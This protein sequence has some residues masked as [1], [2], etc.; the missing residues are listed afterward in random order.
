M[1][2]QIRLLEEALGARLFE[3]D[4]RACLTDAGQRLLPFIG[5]AFDTIERASAKSS[6]RGRV[7]DGG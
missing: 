5:Q 6:P 2:R 7:R 1:S 4:H 3:R